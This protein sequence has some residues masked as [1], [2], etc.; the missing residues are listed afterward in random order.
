[1]GDL[2]Y[3]E[4]FVPVTPC[5]IA[6]TRGVPPFT[7]AY[8]GPELVAGATR[9][10]DIFMAPTCTGIPFGATAFS[11]NFTV[12][13]SPGV[14][15]NAFLTVWPTGGSQPTVSTLN[16]DSGQLRANAAIVPA[17]TGGAVSVFVSAAA[18][19]IIDI[20][21]YF[22]NYPTDDR[23][24]F[25]GGTFDVNGAIVGFNY[26]NAPGSVG[27]GGSA[28]GTGRVYGVLGWIDSGALAGSA[29][30]HGVGANTTG[31][32]TSG[33]LGESLNA[34]N[35]SAGV[36]GR[37]ATSLP[38]FSNLA[39]SAGVR[40]E[41]ALLGVAGVS[42]GIGRG[43]AGFWLTP[44]G[45]YGRW[46]V[47]GDDT[48][49]VRAFGDMGASGT[50]AFVEPHPYKAGTVIRYVALE[51][52]EAGTY[53]RGRGRF[54]GG[55]AVIEV[56]ESFR[57]VTDEEGLTVHVTPIGRATAWV[58]HVG[59]D[60]I[61]AESTRDVEFFYL[62]QGVRKTFK[63]WQ[64]EVESDDFMPEFPSQRIPGYLSEAQKRNLVQ[65]GVYNEDGTV[66]ME[67]AERLGWARRWRERE[68][69]QK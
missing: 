57:L 8:A 65:S 55:K 59:L 32:A 51:G 39:G 41:S 19:L 69:G 34:V 15:Q 63:D 66:N 64:V 38:A 40:G 48:Y 49:G 14:Y 24:F 10:F 5:R 2:G 61:D 6:D 56:P 25:I 44:D 29:G 28:T 20:N 23:P 43:V 16:F 18:H 42:A 22:T 30:V 67:T 33:V 68:A 1:M 4:A 12:I 13:G 60:R 27:V 50:K 58:E 53:F 7:G 21:G 62:V 54:V 45:Y 37:D 35:D 36:I 11:L 31:R 52:P 46:G 26:S 47:L 3:P 9:S 17:G